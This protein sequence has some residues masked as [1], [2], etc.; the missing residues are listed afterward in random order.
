[1]TVSVRLATSVSRLSVLVPTLAALILRDWAAMSRP[2]SPSVRAPVVLKLTLWPLALMLPTL[3]LPAPEFTAT[4][5]VAVTLLKV[6]APAVLRLNKPVLALLTVKALASFRYAAPV[7]LS[8]TVSTEV[9]GLSLL[10]LSKAA[11]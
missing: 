1:M 8:T 5:P 6:V 2:V 4:A 3:K 7:T 11:A 9:S 10:L